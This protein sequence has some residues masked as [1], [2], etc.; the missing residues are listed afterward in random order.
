MQKNITLNAEESLIERAREVAARQH[1]SLNAAFREW[2]LR[3]T[4]A[5]RAKDG[6]DQL[7][8][9]LSHVELGRSFSREEMNER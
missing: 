6:Y 7:M 8:E 1:R 2:L 4:G 3:Y 5:D 9:K